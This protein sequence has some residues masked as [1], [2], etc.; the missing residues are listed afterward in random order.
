MAWREDLSVT[1]LRTPDGGQ[2]WVSKD[3]RDSANGSRL[4]PYLT[5]TKALSE[6]TS[7]RKTIMVLPGEYA[8]AGALVW[9]TDV[10]GI[11]LIGVGN[12]WEVVISASAGDEVITLTPGVQ[13]ST[14]ELTIQNIQFE[15][16]DGQDGLVATND[17][18]TKKLNVYLGN[19]GFAGESDDFSVKCIHGDTDNAIRIYWDGGNGDCEGSIDLAQAND[20]DR[21]YA[22]RIV[23]SGDNFDF[24]TNIAGTVRM[25][26]CEI[27]YRIFTAG[28]ASTLAT[29][30]WCLS[31]NSGTLAA[32]AAADITTNSDATNPVIVG[33]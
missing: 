24:G 7:S 25:R 10:S 12:R 13:T 28:G 6:V 11:Q 30:A 31:N 26:Y 4:A 19:V 17:A 29:L 1:Q 21:F 8:E 16:S 20:G 3:G 32:A 15:H 2:I 27:A 5:V 22:D 9:P 14:F 33:T 23:I 18:M